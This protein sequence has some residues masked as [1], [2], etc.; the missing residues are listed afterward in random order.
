M[1]IN[2]WQLN[3]KLNTALQHQSRADFSLYLALLSPS[4]EESAEFLTPDAI[5]DDVTTDI[6][7]QLGVREARSF[8]MEQ[9]DIALLVRHCDA[10]QQDGLLQ[11]KLMAS[12]NAA[13]IAQYDDK[14]RLSSDVWQN[15]SLH[16]RRHLTQQSPVKPVA[17]PTALYDVLQQL[18][19]SEAA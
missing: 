13:P 12:L 19:A 4:V 6:Y 8:A 10:L 7:K 9:A 18:H 2:E 3:A 11:L 14:N 16:S 17:D 15:L 5:N 1:I